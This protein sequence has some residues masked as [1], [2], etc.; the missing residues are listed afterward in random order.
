MKNKKV[1]KSILRKLQRRYDEARKKRIEQEEKERPLKERIDAIFNAPKFVKTDFWC[2]VCKR[3]CT[4]T[5][6][7][8]VNTTNDQ[9]PTAWFVGYCPEKHKMIRRITDK[10]QDPYYYQSLM[11]NRQ[12]YNMRDDLLTPDDPRFKLLYPKQYEELFKKR[13]KK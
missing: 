3:D 6:Y 8:Q 5:G 1:N 10:V 4:G 9:R 13:N 12:R 11:L 2:P 7:R